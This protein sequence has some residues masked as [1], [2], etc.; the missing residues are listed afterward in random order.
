MTK[1]LLITDLPFWHQDAGNKVRVNALVSYLSRISH[2][3]IV[4]LGHKSHL[5][6]VKNLDERIHIIHLENTDSYDKNRNIHAVNRLLSNEHYKACIIEYIHLSYFLKA[7]PDDTLTILDTHDI[8]SDSNKSFNEFGFGNF[9]FNLSSEQEFKIFSL[10]DHVMFITPH[11]CEAAGKMMNKKNMVLVPHPPLVMERET[12]ESVKKVGFVASDYEPNVDAILWFFSNVWSQWKDK[13][14]PELLIFGNIC[15]RLATI[16][17]PEKVVLRGYVTDTNA[18]Y[19]EIDIV[20]NPIRFGAGLKIKNI[21]ALA[22]SRPLLTTSHGA[23]GLRRNEKPC[24]IIA[25][26]ETTF[27]NELIRLSKHQ[28]HRLALS[29]SALEFVSRFYGEEACF[30]IIKNIVL[31]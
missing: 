30:G 11:D 12:R 26:D 20:V 27:L 8:I 13:D 18:L 4:F 25:D 16:D 5:F 31:S 9:M 1:I 2:V 7:I 3:T 6:H 10:Y 14:K 28:S 24:F 23:K 29:N 22:N 17:L 19:E 21:E 15:H